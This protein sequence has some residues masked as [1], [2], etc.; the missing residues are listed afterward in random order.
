MS[1]QAK[2]PEF[3]TMSVLCERIKLSRQTI[4]NHIEKGLL[5][6]TRFGRSI[7]FHHDD[8]MAYINSSRQ[9]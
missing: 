2:I 1:R 6:P 9:Q 4:Y 3:I 7:R 5:K 8:V